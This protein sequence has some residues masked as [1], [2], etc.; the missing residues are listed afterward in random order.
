MEREGIAEPSEIQKIAI[1]AILARKNVLIIAPT[2]MGKTFAAILPILDLFLSSRSQED[3]KGISILYITPLRALNRD[4]LRRLFEIGKDLGIDIRVRHGDTEAT[5]RARQARFPPNMLITTP[6]TLQAILPGKKMQQHL[7]NVKWAVID[8][9]HEL[10]TDKR[11]T[12]LALALERLCNITQREFQRVGLSA[13]VGEEEKVGRFLAGTHRTAEILKS[14]EL[15]EFQVSIEYV[16]PSKKDYE[17]AD[18]LGIPP[19]AIARTRRIRDLILA[20]KSTLV[21]TNTREHAEA[22]GAQLFALDSELPVK[23][24]HG[25]LSREVREEAERGFQQGMIKGI[26]CTSSLELGID[27]GS[28]DFVVQYMSPREATRLIQRVGRS[29]HRIGAVPKGCVIAT[30]AD[31]ISESSVLIHFAKSENLER[32]RIHENAYDVLAHQI[33]GLLLDSRRIKIEDVYKVVKAAAPYERLEL[34]NFSAVLKQ[35]DRQII[36]VRNSEIFA[37]YPKAFRYYYENLSMIPDVKRYTVFDFIRKR[38]IG[39][40]DEE[41][42]VRRCAPNTEFIMHGNT[43][44]VVSVDEDALSIEVEPTSPSLKAI[45]SW[46]GEIIPVECT[47]A[48]KVGQLREAIRRELAIGQEPV[49]STS[50]SEMNELALRKVE[51]TVQSHVK[52]YPLPTDTTIAVESFENCVVIH[53]CFGNLVNEAFAIALSALLSSRHGVHVTAQADPYRI[54]LIYPL[55]INVHLVANEIKKL[56][57]EELEEIL[58]NAIEGTDI[59]NWRHWHV[60]KRFGAVERKADYK[61]TR[62]R[63]IVDIFRNTVIN[64]ETKREIFLEKLD[65]ENAKLVAQRIISGKIAIEVAEQRGVSCSPLALPIVDKIVPHNLL[66]PVIPAKSLTEIVKERLISQTV[67]LVCIFNADWESIRTVRTLHDKIQ[68]PI[69][70]STLI[71]A[72]YTGDEQLMK[73]VKKKKQRKALSDD[74]NKAWDRAWTSASL[75]QTS[76]KKA[77]IAMSGRGVGPT[78]A[79]RILR[80]HFHTEDEFYAE[81]LKAERQYA[82]TRLFWD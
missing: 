9:I 74:E 33:V 2:G 16:A 25:S 11:G 30:Y 35:L 6:E 82:R 68:C 17:E 41:F 5:E 67:R 78:T 46:E 48:S 52:E 77:V 8:E 14:S 62:A 34:E 61:T 4:L 24:H 29:G 19:A 50:E 37:K 40:L 75:V 49:K 22:L 76:G 60:A 63:L 57:P 36:W 58:H 71:A 10:A 80:K 28:V 45:P 66:R 70:R 42:V 59:F 55:K 39:V 81:V 15:K 32:A 13:T 73:I 12:Q 47:V 72:T 31:D 20:H 26:V 3:A 21:F 56:K 18:R 79:V 38:K 54:A 1:P 27:I 53:S 51:E 65:L 43:W 69:C 23:V 44:K 64:K 7:K